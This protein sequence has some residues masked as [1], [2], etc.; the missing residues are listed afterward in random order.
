M[1]DLN[2]NT[3]SRLNQKL[4]AFIDALKAVSISEIQEKNAVSNIFKKKKDKNKPDIDRELVLKTANNLGFNVGVNIRGKKSISL[5]FI[6][7]FSGFVEDYVDVFCTGEKYWIEAGNTIDHG[8][9][10]WCMPREEVASDR[11]DRFL[12]EVLKCHA[13]GEDLTTAVSIILGISGLA[14]IGYTKEI[15]AKRREQL[16]DKK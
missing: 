3:T 1:S 2:D 11:A 4:I 9:E 6:N 14:S 13:S 7:S 10:K 8:T 5:G 12:I 16:S 15:L